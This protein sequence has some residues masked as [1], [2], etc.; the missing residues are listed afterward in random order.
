MPPNVYDS[1]KSKSFKYLYLSRT[2]NGRPPPHCLSR[3]NLHLSIISTFKPFSE[4]NFAAVDP[5]GPAPTTTTSCCMLQPPVYT[6]SLHNKIVL[7]R[8]LT[9]D[10]FLL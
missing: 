3:G 1:I 8:Q 6:Y 7:G 2:L 5:A 10:E 9:V 4:R